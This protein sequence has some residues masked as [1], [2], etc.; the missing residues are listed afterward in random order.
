MTIAIA[1]GERSR[2]DFLSSRFNKDCL[3]A[4][5]DGG[6]VNSWVEKGVVN[7]EMRHCNMIDL[8][9]IRSP[10]WAHGH[11]PLLFPRRPRP[12]VA[13]HLLFYFNTI[14]NLNIRKEHWFFSMQ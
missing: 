9:E 3:V 2:G 8:E 6:V 11:S 14:G 5:K 4:S 12:R 1:K 7:W 10:A 13:L